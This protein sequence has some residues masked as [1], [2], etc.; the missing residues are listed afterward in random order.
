VE[1]LLPSESASA[2]GLGPEQQRAA[3]QPCSSPH[4]YYVEAMQ[5]GLRMPQCRLIPYFGTFL[6]DLYTI[7]NDLPNVVVVGHDG[8]TEKLKVKMSPYWEQ[9]HNLLFSFCTM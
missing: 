2:A 5:R 9:D 4:T 1:I 6:F 7:V 8:E 3:A